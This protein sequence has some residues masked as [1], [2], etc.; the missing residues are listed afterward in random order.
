MEAKIF[1]YFRVP[2]AHVTDGAVSAIIQQ[3][4]VVAGTFVTKIYQR[5]IGSLP[6]KLQIDKMHFK[7]K[8][9]Y[10]KLIRT[11][12]HTPHNTNEFICKVFTICFISF[13][14]LKLLFI[15]FFQFTLKLKSQLHCVDINCV[16]VTVSRSE[17]A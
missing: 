6:G 10:V 1:S 8:N 5:L 14:K 4:I 15:T 11:H 16:R 12:T 3:S 13:H 7:P 9:K 17:C 2:C